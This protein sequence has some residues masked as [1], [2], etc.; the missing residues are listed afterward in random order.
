M[1]SRK[2]ESR[3]KL[4]SEVKVGERLFRFTCDT[5]IEPLGMTYQHHF[6]IDR[7]RLSE[8]YHYKLRE[9][10]ATYAITSNSMSGLPILFTTVDALP[11]IVTSDNIPIWTLRH[12]LKCLWRQR[13]N[14]F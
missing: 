11:D 14:V 4:L 12:L 5:V 10:H 13:F 7:Y 8:C 2:G 6:K 3:P 9:K 1:E